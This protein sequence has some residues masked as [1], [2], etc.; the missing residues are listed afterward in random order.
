MADNFSGTTVE[1]TKS[2]AA[3][4]IGGVLFGR[5]KIT[6]GG[7]GVDGGDVSSSNPLP[8]SSE[9]VSDL[10]EEIAIRL[11][12]IADS[13]G[14]LSPDVAG[15]LRVTADVVASHAVS[16]VTTVTTVSNQTSI[17][18]IAANQH[19]E[20]LTKMAEMALR[21]NIVFS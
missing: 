4:E 13:V 11:A 1:G 2:F 20:A 12:D 7:D 19:M 6:I 5:S 14:N 18:G 8:I 15:R 16:T 17:G 10:L 3:D 9:Q 21:Q